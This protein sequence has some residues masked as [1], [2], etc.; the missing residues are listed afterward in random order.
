V[1]G[2]A[3][4][5]PCDSCDRQ[6][7]Q[8]HLAASLSRSSDALL[9]SAGFGDTG[10]RCARRLAHGR[11]PLPTP[12]RR[13]STRHGSAPSR[14]RG[15]AASS[16]TTT[17][18]RDRRG[19]AGAARVRSKRRSGMSMTMLAAAAGV[20]RI[21]TPA[22]D[23]LSAPACPRGGADRRR[24]RRAQR[25]AARHGEERADELFAAAAVRRAEE[26]RERL[27]LNRGD[28]ARLVRAA[29]LGRTASAI[30]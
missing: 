4:R 24:L 27:E 16:A 5:W 11:Q 1:C 23:E 9:T 26:R 3:R 20:S 14:R 18:C 13:G 21:V 12:R 17:R 10:R 19:R 29:Q 30:D 15:S 7:I 25:R 28:G 6:R 2:K 8:Q 22:L